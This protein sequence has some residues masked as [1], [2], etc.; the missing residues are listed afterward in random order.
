MPKTI[1]VNTAAQLVQQKL[2]LRGRR[3]TPILEKLVK[4]PRSNKLSLH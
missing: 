3:T 1:T 2:K 4:L